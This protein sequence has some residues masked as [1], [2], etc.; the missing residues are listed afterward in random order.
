MKHLLR[1]G[2]FALTAMLGLGLGLGLGA[3]SLT[4]AQEAQV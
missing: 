4:L 1:I 2:A 3:G